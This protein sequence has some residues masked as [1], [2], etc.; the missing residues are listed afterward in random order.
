MSSSTT[1]QLS[2]KQ[3]QALTEIKKSLVELGLDKKLD[4]NDYE[5]EVLRFAKTK[6]FNVSGTIQMI[7]KFTVILSME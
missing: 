3:Q 6:S 5:G 1:N 2:E 7:K 4:K